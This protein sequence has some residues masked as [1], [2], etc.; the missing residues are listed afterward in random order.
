MQWVKKTF[1]VILIGLIEIRVTINYHSSL[2]SNVGIRSPSHKKY[3]VLCLVHSD[4]WML[5][6]FFESLL[7][8]LAPWKAITVVA[9]ATA[10]VFTKAATALHVRC[11]R[12]MCTDVSPKVII[13]KSRYDLFFFWYRSWGLGWFLSRSSALKMSAILHVKYHTF[14]GVFIGVG[15]CRSSPF[16]ATLQ[17]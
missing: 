2:N 5:L 11:A 12:A 8:F 6:L 9:S 7:H 3:F 4:N 1:L 17:F 13:H 14:D 10:T 15:S 16:S